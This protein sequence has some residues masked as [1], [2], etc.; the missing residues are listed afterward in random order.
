VVTFRVTCVT[1]AVRLGRPHTRA[2]LT[3]SLPRRSRASTSLLPASSSGQRRLHEFPRGATS[4]QR[5]ACQK[6]RV[7]RQSWAANTSTCRSNSEAMMESGTPRYEENRERSLRVSV[8]SR[9]GWRGGARRK[10]IQRRRSYNAIAA[11]AA[12]GCEQVRWRSAA[13]RRVTRDEA[14]ELELRTME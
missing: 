13:R 9:D 3:W 10:D 6:D 4:S 8:Y 11:G 14:F 2:G 12:E 1:L 5:R 7:W